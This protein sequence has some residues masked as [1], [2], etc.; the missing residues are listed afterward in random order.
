MVLCNGRCS[1]STVFVKYPDGKMLET[2]KKCEKTGKVL[3]K[4]LE[5]ALQKVLQNAWG[6]QMYGKM[7]RKVLRRSC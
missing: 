3:D 5:K 2:V 4:V 7:W 6:E 1:I